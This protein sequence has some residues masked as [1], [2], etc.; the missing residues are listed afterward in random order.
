VILLR[1]LGLGAGYGIG[2]MFVKSLF[3]EPFVLLILQGGNSSEGNL[4]VLALVYIGVGLIS[5]LVAAPIFGGLLLLRRGSGESRRPSASRLILSLALALFMGVISGLLTIG[6][7]ATGILPTG[8]VLD[9]LRL[10][11]ASNFP[12]GTPLLVAW[13]MAR[14][15]LP[16]GLT[17]LLLSPVSGGLLQRLYAGDRPRDQKRYEWEE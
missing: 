3:P 7:Y 12:T 5:G 16:A 15:L 11:R 8:G 4:T 6:A 10:I 13:T 2:F 14:D 9:P 17:G 1:L